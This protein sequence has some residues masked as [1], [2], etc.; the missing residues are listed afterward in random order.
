MLQ[1][2]QPL[3]NPTVCSAPLTAVLAGERISQLWCVHTPHTSGFT[4]LCYSK[5]NPPSAPLHCLGLFDW[6]SKGRR[7][8]FYVFTSCCCCHDGNLRSIIAADDRVVDVNTDT[9][10]CVFGVFIFWRHTTTSKRQTQAEI[11]W[12]IN[13]NFEFTMKLKQV[14]TKVWGLNITPEEFSMARTKKSHHPSGGGVSLLL[15]L[16]F[17]VFFH[18]LSCR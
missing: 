15:T 2:N 3:W 12:D 17:L 4:G 9:S 14:K 16:I 11:R 1:Q 8:A 7:Y 6:A 18:D 13:V 5:T 10:G